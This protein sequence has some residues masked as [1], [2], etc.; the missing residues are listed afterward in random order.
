MKAKVIFNADDFGYSNGI[1][2]GIIDSYKYGILTST[3]MLA[4]MSGFEH[5]LKLA[6]ENPGLGIGIHL[7]LTCGKPLLKNHKTLTTEDGFFHN[8]S[9]YNEEYIIDTDEVYNEWDAQINK[10]LNAGIKATHLDSHHHI[11]TF[12]GMKEVFI[13]LARKYNFPVR[14]NF[15]KPKDLVGTQRFET[16]FDQ[17]TII[18]EPAIQTYLNNLIDDIKM[19]QSVEVMCHPGYLDVE[20]YDN[21]SLHIPRFNVVDFFINSKFSQ[22]LKEHPDIQLVHYGQL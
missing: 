13:K 4:N 16:E 12:K 1:N 11:H 15:D 6:S 21:S 19:Y 3:T 14:N 22:K 9:F 8:L 10:I 7:T 5:A 17:V 2:Y 20:V 18:S